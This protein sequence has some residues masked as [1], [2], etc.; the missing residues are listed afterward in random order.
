MKRSFSILPGFRLASGITLFYLSLLVLIPLCALVWKTTELSLDELVATLTNSRVL[1]SFRVSI[2]TALAAALINLF[3]GFV[4]AWVLVRYPMPFKRLFDAVIDLPFAL[5]TAVAG[6]VLAA[7]YAPDGWIGS[8]F[9]ELGIRIAYTPLGIVVALMFIGLPF[10]VRTV[11]PVL[12]DLDSQLEEAAQSLG[13][14]P[15]TIFR[16]VLFPPLIP[17][18]LTGF[19]LAFARGL[20]EYGSVIFIAGNM[21][22]VSEIVPLLIITKLEQ[23]DYAGATAIGLMMLVVAFIMLLV[24][25]MLQAWTRK[26]TGKL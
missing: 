12:Q 17:A 8:F 2:L 9:T 16:R 22:M 19:A 3:L 26:R 1:A 23:Y 13:A 4:I 20:G 7:L 11:E 25:N 6:I 15:W 21:P 10:V 5:P 14:S 24:I 18:L